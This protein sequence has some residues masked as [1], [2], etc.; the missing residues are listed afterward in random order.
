MTYAPKCSFQYHLSTIKNWKQPTCHQQIT[1]Q[2]NYRKPMI[3][4]I[5]FKKICTPTAIIWIYYTIIK[6]MTYNNITDMRKISLI[7]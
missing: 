4:F 2:V 1:G 5:I 6:N 3:N 7:H